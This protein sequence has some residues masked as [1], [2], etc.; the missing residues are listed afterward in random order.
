MHARDQSSIFSTGR[1][2]H[3]DYGL[4]LQLHALTPVARSYALLLQLRRNLAS[5]L[6]LSQVVSKLQNKICNRKPR[7]KAILGVA[8]EQLTVLHTV[9][10]L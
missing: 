10:A 6:V 7:L 2:F 4:L 1:K 8:R 9:E 3:S 5:N